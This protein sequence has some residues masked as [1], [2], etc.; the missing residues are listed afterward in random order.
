MDVSKT[1][2]RCAEIAS[3]VY[4]GALKRERSQV[5]ARMWDFENPLDGIF[6]I[7]DLGN[8]KH[9]LIVELSITALAV[10]ALSAF[11][12][13]MVIIELLEAGS[14]VAQLTWRI[15]NEKPRY[16]RPGCDNLHEL[17]RRVVPEADRLVKLTEEEHV[18]ILA[19]MIEIAFEPSPTYST[20][21]LS[22]RLES[23]RSQ[24]GK[25]RVELI[26]KGITASYVPLFGILLR[27]VSD[28]LAENPATS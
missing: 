3:R 28:E 13:L 10:I 21:Q 25:A 6:P 22:S 24:R 19:S 9:S 18:E 16:P 2:K 20:S 8:T 4:V 12:L 7:R 23:M 26:R 17:W 11:G 14:Q 1:E 5:I 15:L 27:Q